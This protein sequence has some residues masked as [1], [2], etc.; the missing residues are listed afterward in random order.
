MSFFA[1]VGIVVVFLS[2]RGPAEGPRTPRWR[3]P[4]AADAEFD[5]REGA[6]LVRYEVYSL[7]SETHEGWCS[8][9]RRRLRRLLE[10]SSILA[11]R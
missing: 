6:T 2:G 11:P 1:A 9:E 10:P 8:S 5:W 7:V 3:A 4:G